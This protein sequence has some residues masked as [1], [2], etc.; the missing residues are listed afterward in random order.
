M[1][2]LNLHFRL[3]KSDKELEKSILSPCDDETTSTSLQYTNQ[4]YKHV[5]T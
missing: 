1:C 3:N 5:S 2:K 4:T